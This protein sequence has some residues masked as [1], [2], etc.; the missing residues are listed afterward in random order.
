MSNIQNLTV[1][2]LETLTQALTDRRFMDFTINM[3]PE[4]RLDTLK[5]LC[6]SD[7]IEDGLDTLE[8]IMVKDDVDNTFTPTK[9]Y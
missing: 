1:Q 9:Q 8:S 4:E 2:D 7:D 6:S 3:T 5:E